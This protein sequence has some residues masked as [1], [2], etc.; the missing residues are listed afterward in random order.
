MFPRVDLLISY[1]STLVSE[2][3]EQGV[4]TVMHSMDV[5]P[6]QI[7]ARMPEIL[8][9]LEARQTQSATPPPSG[10]DRNP[11]QSQTQ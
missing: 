9:V 3:A 7:L 8:Q 2:Y 10:G 5:T 4:P 1:P 6:D 11:I